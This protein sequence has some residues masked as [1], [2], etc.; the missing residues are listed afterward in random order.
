MKIESSVTSLSWIPSE[1]VKG[2][3]KLGFTMG[4]LHYDEH[5]PE[6]RSFVESFSS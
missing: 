6:L 2:L 1:A 5:L 4:P 3:S